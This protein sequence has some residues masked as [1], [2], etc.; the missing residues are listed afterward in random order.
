MRGEGKRDWEGVEE[1]EEGRLIV[2][3]NDGDEDEENVMVEGKDDDD[4]EEAGSR[5]RN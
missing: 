2:E 5:P 4:E 3:G 1:E